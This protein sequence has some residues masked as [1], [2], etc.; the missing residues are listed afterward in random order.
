MSVPLTGTGGWATRQGSIIGEYN[1]VAA[2]YGSAAT[3]GFN[4]IWAQFAS[5]DQA[6]VSNLPDALAAYR[7]SGQSYQST[8]QADGSLA[9][10]LQVSD[11]TSVVPATL[12]QSFIVL[13]GQMV[14]NSQTIQRATITSSVTPGSGNLGTTTVCLGYNNVYGNP[15]DAIFAETITT[16]CIAAGT[17]YQETLQAV[18]APTAPTNSYLWPAGSG[19]NV[20]FAVTDPAAGGLTTDGGFASWGGTGNN[21]PTYWSI[22]NGAAGVTVFQ[23]SGS[24]VRSATSAA[25]L[26]SDGSSTTKLSQAVTAAINTVYAVSVQAKVSAS[27]GSGTLVIRLTDG[28][29]VVLT[30]DAGNQLTY[31][32]NMSAQVT[33]SYQCFTAM[34]STPRQLPATTKIEVGFGVAPSSSKYMLVDLVGMVAATQLYTGGPFIAAF[35]GGTPTALGDTYAC[36]FTN[37][38]TS[39]SFARGLQRLYNTL[40]MGVYFPSA[41]SPT[42]SDALVLH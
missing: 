15:I 28:D 12:Q 35:A 32:R 11:D 37:S 13:I 22:V 21:T 31:S 42:I 20:Q 30:D 3:T 17:Q 23:A 34:F 26:L 19:A 39:Q 18:G 8:L 29:G 9:S 24:G 5:S 40:Q 16:N 36:A 6:A 14:A 25:K 10:I 7:L 33:T 4:A 2:L 38:L 27:D 41:N 1:R